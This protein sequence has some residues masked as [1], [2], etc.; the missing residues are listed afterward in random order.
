MIQFAFI[1]HLYHINEKNYLQ[2]RRNGIKCSLEEKSLKIL[3]AKEKHIFDIRKIDNIAFNVVVS[4]F[5]IFNILYWVIFLTYDFNPS[6][7]DN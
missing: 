2:K 3:K 6:L 1:L 4:S 5:I 7:E